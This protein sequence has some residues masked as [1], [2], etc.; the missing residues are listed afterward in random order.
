MGVD[1]HIW[2]RT[3]HK[4]TRDRTASLSESDRLSHAIRDFLINAI[5][6]DYFSRL[7][8]TIAHTAKPVLELT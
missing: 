1:C 6:Y 8:S 3:R 5:G 7:L 2:D 4:Q